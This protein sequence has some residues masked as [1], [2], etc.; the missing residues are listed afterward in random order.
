[1]QHQ[2]LSVIRYARL[3]FASPRLRVMGYGW[4]LLLGL[5]LVFFAP[6]VQALPSAQEEGRP[7]SPEQPSLVVLSFEG[8]VT[9]V[10]ENYID[11]GIERAMREEAAAVVLQLDTPGGSVEVTKSIIQ[12]MLASPVP[13]VVYVAP[14]GAR[15]GS[16][17]T[18]I[19]LAGHV[20]AMAPGTTIGAASPV[21][22]SGED[23]G[24]TMES[25]IVNILS[26][27][28]Q[29]LAE[30][31]GEEATD[32]AIAAVR[33]AAAATDEEALDLGVIDLIA[34]DVPELAEK[35]HGR[36]VTLAGGANQLQTEGA[37][38]IDLPMSPLQQTLNFL[39]DPNLAT[40]LLSLGVLGLVVEVRSPGFG[41]PGILGMVCLL[42]ALYA[43]GQLDANLAGLALMAV[44]FGLLVAEAFTPTFGVLAVGGA[45][46]FVLGGALL[47]DGPGIPVP[48]VTL[49]IVAVTMAGL[50]ILAGALALNAQR[51]PIATGGEAI[52]G[53]TATVKSDIAPG[54]TGNV[55]VQGEWWRAKLAG[56]AEDDAAVP[57][58]ASVRVVERQG[59]T[60]IVEP[61][62]GETA[63]PVAQSPAAEEDTGA[64]TAPYNTGTTGTTT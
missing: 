52:L 34:A 27:D 16:A 15:A 18:F 6:P 56:S 32:W 40:I 41:I 11:S 20:A 2:L 53:Q 23:V 61:I 58:G 1:M 37:T 43:L 36:E 42:M 10:L 60:L 44:A 29:N 49:G 26:A 5:I 9:P 64:D 12:Q 30:R 24:E 8:G 13:L 59:F 28:I 38:L 3:H 62:P 57:A 31:R 46:A 50:V 33:E 21:G 17:G 51:N 19:T 47:F 7:E 39:V 22:M 35:L 48:W 14:A 63:R 25:K 55:F 45:V 54:E 4:L